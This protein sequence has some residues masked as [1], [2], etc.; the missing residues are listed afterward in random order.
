ME[1]RRYT[2]GLAALVLCVS[3]CSSGGRKQ[4][5]PTNDRCATTRVAP[6]RPA[7]QNARTSAAAE[8]GVVFYNRDVGDLLGVPVPDPHSGIWFLIGRATKVDLDH[9]DARR[10]ARVDPAAQV[11]CGGQR[12]LESGPRRARSDA[13]RR[14]RRHRVGA[15]PACAR[16][17]HGARASTARLIP[18]G[19]LP[20]NHDAELSQPLPVRGA[21]AQQVLAS[22]GSGH[23]AF[24]LTAT[25]IIREYSATTGR[26]TDLELP[27]GADALSLRYFA[28]RGLA[29]GIDNFVNGDRTHTIVA[30]PERRVVRPDRGGKRRGAEPVLGLSRDRRSVPRPYAP[31]PG[32]HHNRDRA[33]RLGPGADRWRSTRP[34]RNARR[35]DAT[36]HHDREDARRTRSSWRHSTMPTNRALR[37]PGEVSSVPLGPAGARRSST[38]RSVASSCPTMWWS[39]ADGSIWQFITQY[40]GTPGLTVERVEKY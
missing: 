19:P 5:A 15:R 39:V 18:F 8:R 23:V 16:R 17:G 10:H 26:F 9:L 30:Q 3:A 28:D 31:E 21:H 25:S 32:R 1:L 14:S 13:G 38:R 34:E 27:T 4:S 29:I 40:N 24:A 22:D 11:V 37:F 12:E 2:L 36:G 20:D 35:G 33:S 6:T 7:G